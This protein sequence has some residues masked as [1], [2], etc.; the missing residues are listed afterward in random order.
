M[1]QAAETGTRKSRQPCPP[2]LFLGSAI[3]APASKHNILSPRSCQESLQAMN[4][5][6]LTA[7][8]APC[9]FSKALIK[10]PCSWLS[11]QWDFFHHRSERKAKRGRRT[12]Y[13]EWVRQAGAAS[14]TLG[15]LF[16]SSF[17]EEELLILDFQPTPYTVPATPAEAGLLHLT[18]G[19][20]YTHLPP[21]SF[22]RGLLQGKDT[23]EP[24][25]RVFSSPLRSASPSA[26]LV[27]SSGDS[28]EHAV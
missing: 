16:P 8:P 6:Q 12:L 20:T 24:A 28:P 17:G 14:I 4:Q 18:A 2:P 3:G 21:R 10:F 15:C 9:S 23:N 25:R 7:Q 26:L 19:T 22:C 5:K 27:A 13:P 11:L 1:R